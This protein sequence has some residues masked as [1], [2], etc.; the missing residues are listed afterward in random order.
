MFV[1]IEGSDYYTS[2][3]SSVIAQ[4]PDLLSL[5][6]ALSV[7]FPSYIFLCLAL[8]VLLWVSTLEGCGGDDVGM[9]TA[10]KDTAAGSEQTRQQ[11]S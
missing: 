7:S 1:N 9:D 5:Y 11:R 8:S 2:I 10:A 6:F 4:F 3:R